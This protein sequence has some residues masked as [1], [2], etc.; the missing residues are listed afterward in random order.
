MKEKALRLLNTKQSVLFIF[1]LMAIVASLQSLNGSMKMLG[2]QLATRYN[3][4]IIYKNSFF[5]LIHGQN[6]YAWYPA[7]YWDQYKYMPTFATFFSFFSLFDNWIGL[8]LWNSLNVIV[9]FLGIFA[10]P[11]P[12]VST[13]VKIGFFVLI[14]LITSLQ[15]QQTNALNV[16][17]LLLGFAYM[18]KKHYF[19]AVGFIVA[20]FY[21][22]I[23]G[24]AAA[25]IW[26]FY[27]NKV[28]NLF[29]GIFWLLLLGFAPMI[30]VSFEQ[31]CWQ[32]QNYLQLIEEDHSISYGL[33]ALNFIRQTTG[34]EANKIGMI[35]IG[36][37]GTLSPLIWIKR[38]DNQ[39]FRLVFFGNLLI[40]LIVFNHKSESPTFILAAVGV[41]LWYFSQA[42]NKLNLAL[43]VGTFLFAWLA[44]TDLYPRSIRKEFFEP[45]C[46]KVVPCLLVWCKAVY[47][48]HFKIKE[49]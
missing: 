35:L 9:L 40:F 5:H 12:Q 37:I 49:N 24:I 19:W 7:E 4:F 36:L 43:L 2:G 20:T 6:L 3:N 39:V 11:F 10:L 26:L 30:Y 15:S 33:S 17:L 34:Y 48:L 47:D 18:E 23:Y 41:A 44:P 45:Y 14:E 27:D 1:L 38:Y 46:I 21:I 8:N 25:I 22:K 32:Y 29:Y 28:K 31:L 42:K 16:G 13:K